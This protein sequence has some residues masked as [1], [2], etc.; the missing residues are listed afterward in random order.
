MSLLCKR[1]GETSQELI[2]LGQC[3]RCL[4]LS[5]PPNVEYETRNHIEPFSFSLTPFQKSISDLIIEKAPHRSLFV[6]AVCGAGK[7]EICLEYVKDCLM[8]GLKICWAI[9]RREVVLDLYGRLTKYFPSV[10]LIAVCEGYT[11]IIFGQFIICTTHQLYRYNKYFDVMILDEPDAFPYSG[12]KYLERL[13]LNAAK[14]PIIYLSATF[15]IEGVETLRLPI[16]PSNVLLP[17]PMIVLTRFILIRF[18]ITV[19]SYKN[20]RCLIFVPTKKL[21]K[22]ISKILKCSY[23]TS[24]STYKESILEKFKESKSL[25][26]CTTVLERGVTFKDCHVFVLYAQ[27]RV[28][29]EASLVQ[30]SGRA[31]RGMNPKEGDVWF[32]CLEYSKAIIDAKKRI[33]LANKDASIAL[34]HFEKS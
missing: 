24:E 12:N 26:V 19:L 1:C 30:I 14:G 6:D 7:T 28:F 21:A 25:L 34:S 11:D 17:V 3:R 13:V 27:H 32:F 16:R 22:R 18:I 4:G 9:P 8:K 15:N 23:I 20:K 29:S 33:L 10:N 5:S 31:L 2:F